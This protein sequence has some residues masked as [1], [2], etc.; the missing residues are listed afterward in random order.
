MGLTARETE[1]IP[2]WLIWQAWVAAGDIWD[3]KMYRTVIELLQN[4]K[5]DYTDWSHRHI[6]DRVRSRLQELSDEDTAV[7]RSALK[8]GSEEGVNEPS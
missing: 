2:D 4:I 8:L 1:R 7:L 5:E 3:G 6:F